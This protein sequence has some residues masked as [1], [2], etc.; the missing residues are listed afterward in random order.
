M[1]ARDMGGSLMMD[2]AGVEWA[3]EG[4]SK[5]SCGCEDG[6]LGTP[7][8]FDELFVASGVISIAGLSDCRQI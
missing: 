2:W 3:A 8:D 6:A 7:A 5:A 1:V 4:G